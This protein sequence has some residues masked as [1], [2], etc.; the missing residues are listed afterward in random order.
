MKSTSDDIG[1]PGWDI[2]TGAGRLNMFRA[3]TVTAPSFIKF[4]HPTQD[5]ATLSDSL[6]INATVLSPLFS[7]YSLYYGYG[8]NPT[9]WIPL[10]EQGSN[11]FS[12]E[13]IYN[14]SLT[15]LPD[16]T[17]G[18]RLVVQLTNGRTLEERVNFII[19][20]NP[21]AAALISAGPAFY[22]DKTTILAAMYTDEPCVTRMYY[23]KIGDVQF[24]FITLDGF[25]TNNQFVKYL[26][27]GFIP[28]HLVEQ[29]SVYEVYFEAENLVGLSDTVKFNDGTIIDTAYTIFDAEYSAETLLPFSLPPGSIYQ[30]PVNITQNDFTEVYLRTYA[31]SRVT[32]LFKLNND[33]FEMVDSLQDQI[34]R[35]FGDFNNNGLNDLLNSWVRNGYILEQQS[36]NSSILDQKYAD[37]SGKFWPIMAEDIDGDNITE[38]VAVSSDTSFTIWK[39]NSDL[40]LSNPIA[41][42]NFTEES[43]GFNI[44][45]APNGVSSDVNNDGVNETVVR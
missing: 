32:N 2:Y 7:D 16:T 14:L 41:L 42:R 4:N 45:D 39:V 23:R 28:K 21:P 1:E 29:N 3:V 8:L 37:E 6:N 27:Y 24:N 18:L 40:T 11:Q 31:N 10:I 25:T 9:N 35:D 22:G 13:D 33:A 34:V 38:V 5:F 15:S 17:Y 19:S 12:N 36:I 43:F 44:L 30:N 20:R 26:H